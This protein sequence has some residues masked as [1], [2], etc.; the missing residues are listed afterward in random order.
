MLKRD[1]DC[2]MFAVRTLRGAEV[3]WKLALDADLNDGDQRS[4]SLDDEST[5][6]TLPLYPLTEVYLPMSTT[7]IPPDKIVNHTLN[8][9]E[10]QNIKMTPCH[11]LAIPVQRITLA[12]FNLKS[13]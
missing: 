1:R 8:N 11:P 6:L 9:V 7:T 12:I 13:I 4:P 5:S 3:D 10:P 2:D